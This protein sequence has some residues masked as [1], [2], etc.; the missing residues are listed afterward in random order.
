MN[1]MWHQSSLSANLS[2][3]ASFANEEDSVIRADR[4]ATDL[5]RGR[6]VVLWGNTDAYIIASVENGDDDAAATVASLAGNEARLVVTAE[7]AQTLGFVNGSARSQALRVPFGKLTATDWSQRV[8]CAPLRPSEARDMLA[9]AAARP[10]PADVVQ[11]IDLAKACHLVPALIVAPIAAGQVPAVERLLASGRLLGVGCGD[12]ESLPL[13]NALT[14]KKVSEARVPLVESTDTRFIVFRGA[15]GVTEQVAIQIG[16]PDGKT[17]PMVRL[18]SACL[19]GDLFGS[20]RCDCGEQLRGAV[21]TIADNG[22]GLI[23]YLAQEG[24]G[25]GLA[26]KMRTYDLQDHGLDTI[27]SDSLLG[28]GADERRYEIAVAM[29]RALDIDRIRVMTNNPE[30]IAHL[31]DGGIEVVDRVALQSTVNEHNYRYLN[32]KM[33]R[34]GHMLDDS[35][36]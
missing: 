8:A 19:T 2:D 1:T 23:L 15:D 4:A 14:L 29:L 20:L 36:F 18:H 34:A 5:R 35:A 6:P 3:N 9:G 33:T 27:D 28:F 10:A 30:K 32:A 22:W 21:Q 11:A 25:I 7:R 17:A 24:R 16:T 12:I 26:N 13:N 31:T